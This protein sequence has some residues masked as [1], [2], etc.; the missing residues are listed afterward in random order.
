MVPTPSHAFTLLSRWFSTHARDLPWRRTTDPW[1]ILVCEIMSQQTPV[2]RVDPVWREWMERW[3][4][5]ADLAETSPA[6]VLIAWSTM[7][8]PRRALRLQEAAQDIAERPNGF[9]ATYEELL[10]LPG[11]G[12]Y[13]AAA[14]MAF[15]FNKRS[16]VL[17]TNIRRG[18][19]RWHGDALPAPSQTRAEVERAESFVPADDDAATLW[20]GAIMEFGALVCTARAP[21]CEACP[22]AD[23]CEWL[24]AGRPADEHA[25]R[26]RPQ[27]WE[28]TNRQ[29][30]GAI[31]AQLR[32]APARYDELVAATGLELARFAPALDGLLTDGLVVQHEDL[33]QLPIASRP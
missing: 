7:G 31:M 12:S 5:P 15:A 13:T 27:K 18:L 24:Q 2:A 19:A 10:E 17:D 14:V 6:E 23:H 25:E 20:N 26:R 8:Y 32:T 3:P 21:L 30:R 16:V 11:V 29:A 22:L 28:G 33:F 1:A 4:P 9:P